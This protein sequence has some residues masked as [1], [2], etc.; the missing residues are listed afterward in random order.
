MNKLCPL[1]G[2]SFE[3]DSVTFLYT[4]QSYAVSSLTRM[5]YA[6]FAP[7][8][9]TTTT[10]ANLVR[11]DLPK[12]NA[13]ELLMYVGPQDGSYEGDLTY[14][15]L[16]REL[17]LSNGCMGAENVTDCESV[18]GGVFTNGLHSVLQY[19]IR[20][21]TSMMNTV[22]VNEATGNSSNFDD[23]NSATWQDLDRIGFYLVRGLFRASTIRLGR[24]QDYG[25]KFATIMS[26][27]Q[28]AMVIGLVLVFVLVYR[29]LIRRLNRDLKNARATLLM[30]PDE[31]VSSVPAIRGLMKDFA[32]NNRQRA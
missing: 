28:A 26:F 30:F 24:I 13:L 23:F 25:A 15:P 10:Y 9:E 8:A 12:L 29:P 31:V 14:D 7:D 3:L 6:V 4:A 20:L 19:Y 22:T 17:M 1:I 11:N 32:R 16:S 18:V 27:A 5:M 2:I 21:G